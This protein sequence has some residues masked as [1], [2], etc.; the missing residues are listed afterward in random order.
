[1]SSLVILATSA[2]SVTL[3]ASATAIGTMAFAVRHA[4]YAAETTK[5][6]HQSAA[7]R[8]IERVVVTHMLE[9]GLSREAAAVT[10]SDI[11]RALAQD[12]KAEADSVTVDA[13][14]TRPAKT[15]ETEESRPPPDEP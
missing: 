11:Y 14:P 2:G 15:D 13:L 6:K 10:V 4:R 5:S 12:F 8:D 7:A 3:A 9:A 1:V